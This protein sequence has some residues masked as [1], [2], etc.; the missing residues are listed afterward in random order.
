MGLNPVLSNG[1]NDPLPF[2]KISPRV[3]AGLHCPLPYTSSINPNNRAEIHGAS[4]VD[5][6]A[7]ASKRACPVISGYQ[8]KVSAPGPA[9]TDLTF[10]TK[11][12]DPPWIPF[13]KVPSPP[14]SFKIYS[15][16]E[17]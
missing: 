5:R 4:S 16:A 9:N 7:T 11:P 14:F 2:V 17:G 8:P 12:Q 3:A 1:L 13:S 6:V 10:C 15:P